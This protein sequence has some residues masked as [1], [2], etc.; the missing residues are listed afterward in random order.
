MVNDCADSFLG[1]FVGTKTYVEGPEADASYAIWLTNLTVDGAG[2]L[3]GVYSLPQFAGTSN[4]FDGSKNGNSLRFK[5][6]PPANQ[7][8]VHEFQGSLSGDRIMGSFSTQNDCNGSGLWSVSRKQANRSPVISSFQAP[9]TVMV[10]ERFQIDFRYDDPD[11][12]A[13]V[14]SAHLEMSNGS[15]ADKLLKGSGR[16]AVDYQQFEL[17]FETP[18]K[19]TFDVYIIDSKGD[20]SLVF[21]QYIEVVPEDHMPSNPTVTVSPERPTSDDVIS[22]TIEGNWP[23]SCAP[24]DAYYRWGNG[25]LYVEL[26]PELEGVFCMGVV[27][28]YVVD[29]ELGR[30]STGCYDLSLVRWEDN[31]EHTVAPPSE[32]CIAGTNL[33]PVVSNLRAPQQVNQGQNFSISFDYADPNG[34]ANVQELHLVDDTAF[35]LIYPAIWW[36]GT[37]YED[38]FI[39][40]DLLGDRNL[41]VYAVDAAGRTSNILSQVISVK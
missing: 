37:Y 18:G 19:H 34:L 22:L 28:P 40:G 21:R 8:C 12:I 15:V 13:D 38:R 25:Y 32:I 35:H 17:W 23:N 36:N 33:P 7:S 29:V 9:E 6:R 26:L 11:G 1:N 31:E 39:T 4:I 5:A 3:N 24:N 27:T 2:R 41:N 16:W 20:H 10:D 30:Q 14:Q